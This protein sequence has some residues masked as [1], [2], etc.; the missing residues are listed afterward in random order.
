MGP[1]GLKGGKYGT[2]AP[3]LIF[4]LL[5]LAF[6]VHYALQRALLV[7]W[8]LI[9]PAWQRLFEIVLQCVLPLVRGKLLIPRHPLVPHCSVVVDG[10]EIRVLIW[11]TEQRPKGP[12]CAACAA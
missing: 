2:D 6:L 5:R 9:V 3:H 4:S 8:Q 10:V 11:R 7:L 1:M 12:T